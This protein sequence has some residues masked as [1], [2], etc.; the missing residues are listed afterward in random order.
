MLDPDET[1][2]ILASM[3]RNKTL[4]SVD[5]VKDDKYITFLTNIRLDQEAFQGTNTLAYLSGAPVMR[6]KSFRTLAADKNDF[7]SKVS[8][9]CQIFFFVVDDK[10][11]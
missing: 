3:A 1:C 10:Q 4:L 11:K 2:P 7:Q 5:N 9:C 6:K 8:F